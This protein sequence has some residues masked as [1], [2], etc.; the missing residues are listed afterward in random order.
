MPVVNKVVL[1]VGGPSGS[2]EYWLRTAPTKGL[3]PPLPALAKE[4]MC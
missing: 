3:S 2:L 4:T 1:Q